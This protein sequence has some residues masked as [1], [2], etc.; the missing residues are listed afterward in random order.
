MVIKHTLCSCP[1][2]VGSKKQTKL[3]DYPFAGKTLSV[4]LWCPGPVAGHHM[5]YSKQGEGPQVF[6]DRSQVV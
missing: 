5:L 4:P 6:N 2:S 3:I 1:F